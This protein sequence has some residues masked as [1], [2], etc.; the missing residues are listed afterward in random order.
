MLFN[1]SNIFPIF[2]EQKYSGQGDSMIDLRPLVYSSDSNWNKIVEIREEDR[3]G[4]R[5]NS[6]LLCVQS[7]TSIE[8]RPVVKIHVRM[9][10]TI[11]PSFFRSFYRN[12]KHGPRRKEG[13]ELTVGFNERSI[14]RSSITIHRP[15]REDKQ[16]F[17]LLRWKER[18]GWIR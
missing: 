11:L 6:S 15:L 7:S 8:Q 9:V 14:N 12:E 13:R 17:L 2:L 5:K 1:L 10:E 18:W 4:G 16:A 3:W